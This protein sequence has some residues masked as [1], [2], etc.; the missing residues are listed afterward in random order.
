MS[1]CKAWGEERANGLIKR[2]GVKHKRLSEVAELCEGREC[3]VRANI[4]NQSTLLQ[5]TKQP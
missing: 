1:S 3:F 4:H 2:K 5:Y